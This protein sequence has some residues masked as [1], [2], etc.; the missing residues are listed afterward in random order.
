MDILNFVK[1]SL[2]INLPAIELQIKGIDI[3]LGDL[4]KEKVA[5]FKLQTYTSL[6]FVE[7]T[8]SFEMIKLKR[9][10]FLYYKVD[11]PKE[12]QD[13]E[14]TEYYNKLVKQILHLRKIGDTF[15]SDFERIISKAANT[16]RF[17]YRVYS[18]NK[19][20]TFFYETS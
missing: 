5:D 14:K 1:V 16:K 19:D 8:K 9:A 11:V 2:K 7:W 20:E 18:I 3:L 10:F 15:N 4:K 17:L 12:K 13:E 6:D